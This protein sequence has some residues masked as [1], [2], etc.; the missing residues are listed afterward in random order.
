VHCWRRPISSVGSSG[1]NNLQFTRPKVT[2]QLDNR[3]KKHIDI[4][5]YTTCKKFLDVAEKPGIGSCNARTAWR[6]RNGKKTVFIRNGLG[7][8]EE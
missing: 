1:E 4:I 5:N 2:Q 6:V 7:A 8:F 3:L